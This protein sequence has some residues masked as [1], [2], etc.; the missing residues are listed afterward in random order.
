MDNTIVME[1]L[2]ATEQLIHEML[3]VLFGQGLFALNDLVQV[4]VH[5]LHHNIK[6]ILCLSIYKIFQRN[7]VFVFA[8]VTK[9][10]NFA[11]DVFGIDHMLRNWCHFLDGHLFVQSLRLG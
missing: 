10:A 3:K 7:D 8:H 9:Q 1:I 11:Q 4:R 6:L 5:Q 2:Q